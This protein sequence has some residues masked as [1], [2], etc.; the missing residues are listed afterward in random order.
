MSLPSNALSFD[1]LPY[2]PHHLP[3]LV[4][5]TRASVQHLRVT[6]NHGHGIPDLMGD[7]RR[8]LSQMG[9]ALPEFDLLF[10][11]TH[12]GQIRKTQDAAEISPLTVREL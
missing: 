8:D 4:V 1:F 6:G 5:Q 12:F 2:V 11:A 9:E 7:P 3:R 10:Q